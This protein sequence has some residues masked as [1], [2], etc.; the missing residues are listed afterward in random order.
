MTAEV[1]GVIDGIDDF[2]LGLP[3][4]GKLHYR[5]VVPEGGPASGL[6]FVIPGMG[7]DM[8]NAYNVVATH[9]PRETKGRS[10][11]LNGHVDVV[12][13]G[14]IEHW[15]SNPFVPLVKDGF[16]RGRNTYGVRVTPQS[17]KDGT[18]DNADGRCFFLNK[19]ALNLPYLADTINMTALP[20]KQDFR[21]YSHKDTSTEI[22]HRRHNSQAQSWF[23][24]RHADALRREALL[25][26]PTAFY[27]S[28]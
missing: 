7:D 21:F 1:V 26:L 4:Q 18:P 15:T 9:R 23:P 11:I 8:D 6:V 17:S 13:T 27:S 19:V 5:C 14:P 28:P 3:R 22:M 20:Y 24:D 2:E 12:P 25:T 10:L 16:V